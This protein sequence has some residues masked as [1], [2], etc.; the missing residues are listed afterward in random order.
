MNLIKSIFGKTP[1]IAESA[2]IS[3]AAVIIG[4]VEIGEESS[5]WPC[6]VIRGDDGPIRIGREVHIQDN[7]VV[8]CGNGGL[9][10]GT[11]VNIG[12]GVVVHCRR[13][14]NNV[15]IANNATILDD[16]EIGNFCMVAAGAVVPPRTKVPDYSFV[17]GVP[18]EIK[19][20]IHGQRLEYLKEAGAHY[21][22]KAKEYKKAGV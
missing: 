10:I 12:H 5:V 9:E 20:E 7:S 19:P 4:D 8:H 21:T 22:W 17:V 14:G 15:L 13:I 3:D 11:K 6:A 16:V 18:A 2:Y 1:R